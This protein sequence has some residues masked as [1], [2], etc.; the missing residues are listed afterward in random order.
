M[1]HL[2]QDSGGLARRPDWPERLHKEIEKARHKPFRWGRNDCCTFACNCVKAMTGED[3]MAEFRRHYKDGV[4]AREAL[5]TIGSGSLYHTARR[6]FGNPIPVAQAH[7]G[8]LALAMTQNGPTLFVILGE[9]MVGPGEDGLEHIPTLDADRA[10]R[11]G[12][13]AARD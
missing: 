5:K 11:V 7:R 13:A 1:T 4:S 6:K 9:K 8:D 12:W 10:F 2:R 3:P